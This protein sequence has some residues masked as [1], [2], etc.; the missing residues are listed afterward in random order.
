MFGKTTLRRSAAGNSTRAIGLRSFKNKY[1]EGLFLKGK[2]QLI[3]VFELLGEVRHSEGQPMTSFFIVLFCFGLFACKSN[4]VAPPIAQPT[5][6]VSSSQLPRNQPS[7]R[8]NMVSLPSCAD[9]LSNRVEFMTGGSKRYFHLYL[10][11]SK[12]SKSVMILHGNGGSADQVLGL[13][14]FPTSSPL[15][16]WLA[17]AKRENFILIVPDGTKGSEGKLGWNDCRSDSVGNPASDDV[18]FLSA[19]SAAISQKY[20]AIKS[21]VT[22]M[23]NGG[24]MSIRLATEAPEIFSGIAP[25]SAA[26]AS[27]SKCTAKNRPISVLLMRG[28][29]DPILPFEGG[30]M[31]G[32][33]GRVFSMDETLNVFLSWNDIGGTPSRRSLPNLNTGDN[34]TVECLSYTEGPSGT[35]VEGLVVLG[36]GHTE[37]STTEYYAALFKRI[38]GE[39]NRDIE[40]AEVIWK[41]FSR[42]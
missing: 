8:E 20:G 16:V 24:H 35:K 11:P 10:P 9:C 39:Q 13:S 23:S 14:L 26:V 4:K 31:A 34:S 2:S 28:T 37:P 21:F 25:I 40:S 3:S 22:G 6:T 17:I 1:I 7:D 5:A 18:G 42:L 29:A 33:R 38:V 27:N 19:L 12:A 30:A 15:K 36:G 32:N 41:F